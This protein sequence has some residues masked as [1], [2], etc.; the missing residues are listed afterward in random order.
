MTTGKTKKTKTT[1]SCSSCGV[2]H[3]RWQG[4]CGTCGAW[5]TITESTS[6]DIKNKP[7]SGYSGMVESKMSLLKD[8][9]VT[10]E[11]RIDSGLS[12]F[13]RVLGGGIVRGSAVLI[14][15]HPG[16]GKSTLLLQM[17]CNL[18]LTHKVLYITGEESLKQIALRASR[19]SLPTS[20]LQVMPETCLDKITLEAEKHQPDLIVID[21]IQVMY[22]ADISSSPGSVS[23]VRESAS[24]LTRFAKVN[25]ITVIMVG[26]VTKDGSLAGPKVL[27]HCI[28]CS[29]LLEGGADSRFR[30]LRC[31]KNRFG[32][33][34]EIGVFAMTDK[35]LKE[36]A[37]PSAMF[38]AG[39]SFSDTSGSAIMPIWEGTRSLLIE[40]QSLVNAAAT[41]GSPRRV[42]VGIDSNRLGLLLAVLHKHCN[43]F[44]SDCDIFVNVVGGVKVFESGVDLALLAAIVS[45]FNNI[46][47]PKDV[48]IFGEVG[49]SGEIRPV[50]HAC[51]RITEA[52]KH[53]FKIAMVPE[54]NKSNLSKQH[55]H[56]K[57]LGFNTVS[58]FLDRLIF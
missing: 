4:Q 55:N 17:T 20:N 25:N 41:S 48:I 18:S 27:E 24:Y 46:V 47:I 7:Y 11:D 44:I 52:Q 15:G 42:S 12:E 56:I 9:D 22:L 43:L 10:E 23:Q 16:A 34:N 3:N 31:N 54:R 45:S 2:S 50:V 35:G 32:A 51:D 40:I 37:N 6:I 30:T 33:I 8:I 21:S 57:V 28:D 19:L 49:L 38:L 1:Y 29:L 39:S 26:H 13:N 58:E 36:V 53:G 14:G 5:N